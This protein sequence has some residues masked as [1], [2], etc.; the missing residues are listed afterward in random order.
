MSDDH[1]TYGFTIYAN[2]PEASE[3]FRNKVTDF[4]NTLQRDEQVPADA[5]W[6]IDAES[7]DYGEKWGER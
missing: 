3:W 2:S 7:L 4:L 6:D 5:E 1:N